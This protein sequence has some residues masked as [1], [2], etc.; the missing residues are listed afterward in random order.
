[1]DTHTPMLTVRGSGGPFAQPAR[2]SSGYL[3]EAGRIRLLVDCGGGVFERLGRTGV[4]PATLS[5]VLLTH[6]HIDHSGGLAPVLFAAAMAGRRTPVPVVGPD[7]RDQHPG[8]R[9]FT[10]LLFGEQ[11]AWS[12]LNTFPGFGVTPTECRS[13]RRPSRCPTCRSARSACRTA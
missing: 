8:C 7:G 6:T 9:R 2:A 12:Y 11:G 10:E 3:L 5:A 4:D 13:R 1:M